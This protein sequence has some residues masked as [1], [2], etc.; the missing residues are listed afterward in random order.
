[1]ADYTTIG[2]NQFLVSSNSVLSNSGAVS[3]Y[4]FQSESERSS[5]PNYLIQDDAV[6]NRK[7]VS[8][9][10][11]KI[12]AGTVVVAVTL[13]TSASG[14]L[15]LDGANNRLIVYGGTSGTV[16]QIVIGEV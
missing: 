2:L 9:S 14:S 15:I 1:M 13:G 3:A 16:P 5:I 11:D 12:T 4:D 10:A 8:V 7:I 6:N